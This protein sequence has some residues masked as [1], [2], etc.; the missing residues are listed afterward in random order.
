MLINAYGMLALAW[1]DDDGTAALPRRRAELAMLDPQDFTF[2]PGSPIDLDQAASV[3][4]LEGLFPTLAVSSHALEV[5][6]IDVSDASPP[7]YAIFSTE[8]SSTLVLAPARKLHE[9]PFV[10]RALDVSAVGSEL[11]TA[12]EELSGDKLLGAETLLGAYSAPEGNLADEGAVKELAPSSASTP[13]SSFDGSSGVAIV[14]SRDGDFGSQ[15][16]FTRYATS[17]DGLGDEV[18]QLTH[19]AARA[20][21]PLLRLSKVDAA[22][23]HYG[24]AWLDDRSGAQ[25]LYFQPFVC[26]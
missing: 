3:G 17:G 26:N 20:E 9:S 8:V 24:L 23:E 12:W 1:T 2:A 13:R 25:K 15:I 6:W 5:S 10:A 11:F 4:G 16:F 18:E 22:G 14:Y 19:V 21:A 7:V